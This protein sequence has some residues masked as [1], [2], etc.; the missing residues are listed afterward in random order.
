MTNPMMSPR[1]IDALLCET[2]AGE[3]IG[4]LD[5]HRHRTY[6][7]ATGRRSGMDRLLAVA[8]L[9]TKNLLVLAET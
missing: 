4:D 8:A 9:S 6:S 3:R 7:S 1:A 5:M 2:R